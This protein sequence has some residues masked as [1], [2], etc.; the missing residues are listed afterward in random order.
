[1]NLLKALEGLSA[2]NGE[3]TAPKENKEKA[4]KPAPEP[5]KPNFMAEV[6]A[7]HERISNRISSKK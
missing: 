6:L 1:L 3:K 5:E 4:E 7:R 2:L